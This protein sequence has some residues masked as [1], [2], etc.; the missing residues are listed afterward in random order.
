VP[1]A[2]ITFGSIGDEK[3]EVLKWRTDKRAY[4]LLAE[5]GTRPRTTYLAELTNPNAAAEPASKSRAAGEH[6]A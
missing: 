1:G 5:L 6:E 4:A 3:S 2:A